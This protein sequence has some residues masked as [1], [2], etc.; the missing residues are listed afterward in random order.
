MKTKWKTG[1]QRD[2]QALLETALTFL[3]FMLLVFGIL[4]FARLFYVQMTMQHAMRVAG[5][6]AATGNHLSNPSSPSQQLGRTNSIIQVAQ[7]AAMGLPLTTIQFV[8]QSFGTNSAGG[9]CDTVTISLGCNVQLLTPLISRVFS[10]GVYRFNASMTY[11]NEP[12]P[13]SQIN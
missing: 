1:R 12:F 7:S 10:N 2:G 3:I 8:S 11:R 5:R 6:Y 13:P 9:P 4:D